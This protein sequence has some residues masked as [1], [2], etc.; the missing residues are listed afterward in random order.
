MRNCSPFILPHFV[1]HVADDQFSDNLD[2]SWKKIKMADLSG[3]GFLINITL[4]FTFFELYLG[5]KVW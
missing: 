3:Q 1:L 5:G 4:N 2:N